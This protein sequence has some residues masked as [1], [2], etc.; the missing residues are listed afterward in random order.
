MLNYNLHQH[1][2][3]SDGKD[4]P[5]KYIEKALELG[6]T[7]MGFSEHSPLPFDNDFSL[8]DGEVDEY[9]RTI[10]RL[11]EKYS[12]RLAVYRALEMDFIPDMSEDFDYWRDRCRTDYLIGSVHLVKPDE[13]DELWFTDGPDYR[14]YDQGIDDFFGG[15]IRKAVKAFYHQTNRM[16]ETQQFEIIGHFDKITMHNWNRFFTDDE[17]WYRRLVDETVELIKQKGL[18]VEVNTRGIYKKRSETFFPDGYALQQVKENNIPVLISSDAHQASEINMLFDEAV[19]YLLD[20]GFRELMFF[21]K[22]IWQ[23]VSLK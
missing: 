12:D 22:G 21:E 20:K 5:E 14:I 15:D 9:I 4:E 18:I 6:F 16:I 3:F 2:R 7:A 23:P 8:K 1:T 17:K 13:T 10:D 19:R 11:K